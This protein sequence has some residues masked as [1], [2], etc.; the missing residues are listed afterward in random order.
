MTSLDDT[1]QGVDAGPSPGMTTIC[2]STSLL[3]TLGINTQN[4]ADW[5]RA[6]SQFFVPHAVLTCCVNVILH[7]SVC[8]RVD[9]MAPP[10]LL[11]WSQLD[12]GHRLEHPGDYGEALLAPAL[13]LSALVDIQGER[14]QRRW[15]TDIAGKLTGECNI[16][17]DNVECTAGRKA[18]RKHAARDVVEC[19]ALPGADR[20]DLRQDIEV[21]AR[22]WPRQ[23][24]P[25]IE[26]MKLV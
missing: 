13:R 6:A 26:A 18:A 22:P 1:A 9:R 7:R 25:S 10:W 23:A 2:R 16:L 11:L 12:S 17:G 24:C 3:P 15:R 20:N 5:W 21:D 19:A 14:T 4:W 8:V